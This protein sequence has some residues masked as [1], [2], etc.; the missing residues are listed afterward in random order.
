MINW[1]RVRRFKR[2]LNKAIKLANDI[3]NSSRIEVP[4]P[5][6]DELQQAETFLRSARYRVRHTRNL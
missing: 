1:F 3:L 6:I 5:V 4:L 2:R